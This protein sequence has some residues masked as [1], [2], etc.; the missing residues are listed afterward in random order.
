[1][2]KRE[3][4]KATKEKE[5]K[6]KEREQK[7][8]ER[9]EK[10][11]AAEMAAKAKEKEQKKQAEIKDKLL[12]KQQKEQASKAKE[13]A[14]KERVREQKEKLR[15]QELAE[16]KA[17]E[18]A[19]KKKELAAK[20]EKK[21]KEM[22]KKD[23]EALERKRKVQCKKKKLKQERSIK[24]RF[25]KKMSISYRGGWTFWGNPYAPLAL[26][27]KGSVCQLEGRLR[28]SKT[29]VPS[30]NKCCDIAKINEA[31]CRPPKT[32]HFAVNH[33]HKQVAI[34]VKAN[35]FVCI[36]EFQPKWVSL[37][38]VIWTRTNYMMEESTAL[39]QEA[40]GAVAV[41]REASDV[42]KNSR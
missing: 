34:Q 5:E 17:R 12:E 18:Q 7:D 40:E 37:S 36:G 28:K 11:K 42:Q 4:E 22:A 16:K 1:M 26:Y 20:A 27:A 41:E 31:R 21:A 9:E 29:C 33:D 13:A 24:N 6:R 8:K 10:A 35:G 14:D 19:E 38:G 23:A 25:P 30:R 39:L 2:G 3:K 15:L 32:L